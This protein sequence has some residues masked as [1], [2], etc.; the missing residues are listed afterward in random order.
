MTTPES[1]PSCAGSAR[2]TAAGL[3]KY[4]AASEATT[5]T[6]CPAAVR[7][8]Y[9]AGTRTAATDPVAPSRTLAIRPLLEEPFE[10]KDELV[11]Q[12]LPRHP[13]VAV[14]HRPQVGEV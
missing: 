8:S 7:A 4:V 1:R 10:G 5:L 11:R 6:A 13:L 12:F 2:P 14:A 3:K 9:R